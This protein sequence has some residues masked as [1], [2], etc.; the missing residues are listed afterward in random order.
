MAMIV[1]NNMGAQRTLNTL[2]K[3]NKKLEKAFSKVA[4]GM[5]IVGADDDSSGY[6]ISEKMRE[7]IRNHFLK[8]RRAVLIILLRNFAR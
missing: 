7:Q 1:K 6:A 5:K 2:N 4:S 3:S 8:R